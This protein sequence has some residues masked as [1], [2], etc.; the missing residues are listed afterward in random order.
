MKGNGI[1]AGTVIVSI[2]SAKQITISNPATATASNVTF[3]FSGGNVT[4]GFNGF[5]ATQ[6]LF[7]TLR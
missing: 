1:P 6:P 7:V 2:D 3:T 5:D 4:L